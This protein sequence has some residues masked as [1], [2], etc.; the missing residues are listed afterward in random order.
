[1]S[2]NRIWTAISSANNVKIILI[3]LEPAETTAPRLR[4]PFFKTALAR[5]RHSTNAS[6]HKKN[7]QMFLCYGKSARP[8]SAKIAE[9]PELL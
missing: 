4:L 3:W 6:M 9:I 5:T 7:G 8:S 1:M 2:E